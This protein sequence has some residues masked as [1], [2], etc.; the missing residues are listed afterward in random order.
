MK[1]RSLFILLLLAFGG[2]RAADARRP[3]SLSATG[4][5]ALALA[6][7]SGQGRLAERIARL[8]REARESTGPAREL[9]ALGWSL[10]EQASL[11]SD[12]GYFKLAEQCA[13]CLEARGGSRGESLLLRGHALHNLHRFHEAE[14]LARELARTRG[15]AADYGLLGDLLMET[16]RL[17]EAIAAY[18]K[19]MELK[20]GPQAYSRAAHARWL[21][22]DLEGA[23][24]MMRLTVQSTGPDQA[25]ARAWA[26]TRLALYALQAGAPAEA[27]RASQI[28]L[29][30][31]PDYAPALAA[32]GRVLMA[33]GDVR[34]AVAP[35][36]RA[37]ALA[38][39]PEF[40]W[41]LA[42]ALRT[43]GRE[44][45]AREVESTLEARGEMS[46]ARTFALYLA[47]RGV[48]LETALRLAT[49]E[50][51]VRADIHT[52]DAL[53]WAQA[54]TGRTSEAASTM[55][56]ALAEGTVDARLFLHAAIISASAGRRAESLRYARRASSLAPMLLPSERALLAR[57]RLR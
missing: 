13:L 49:E 23:I 54:S 51:K 7:L 2:C 35:L 38:P 50:I 42:D 48:Q 25:A 39:L 40:Q 20:P 47:T 52:L 57:L 3:A 14:P 1:Y 33:G 56:R 9:A 22:G 15:L 43:D 16:G 46:D 19:M 5:C 31:Q 24:E 44:G 26:Y 30:L 11:S 17:E 21:K 55:Q 18:Q 45:E 37:V 4:E 36:A 32:L 12:P 27:R 34:R 29:E 8:Q 53:A 28:A 10:V 41:A 6:P